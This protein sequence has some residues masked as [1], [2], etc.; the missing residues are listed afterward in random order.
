MRNTPASKKWDTHGIMTITF[1]YQIK[2]QRIVMIQVL[3]VS[4][5]LLL[6][7]SNTF[8]TQLLR[9]ESHAEIQSRAKKEAGKKELF[10]SRHKNL[11]DVQLIQAKSDEWMKRRLWWTNKNK[12][13]G[14]VIIHSL[15]IA[16]VKGSK[17]SRSD[18]HRYVLFGQCFPGGIFTY[19]SLPDSVDSQKQRI[20]PNLSLL[21][22]HFIDPKLSR[23][24]KSTSVSQ[25]NMSFLMSI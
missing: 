15:E 4:S 7:A 2:E 14:T 3:N 24:Q 20:F 16:F 13:Q 23:K 9:R 12:L 21:L 6:S 8:H 1:C 18:W 25:I 11:R 22:I 5:C 10:C 17:L 19:K